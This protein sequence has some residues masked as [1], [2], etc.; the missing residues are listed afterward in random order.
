MTTKLE[1]TREDVAYL[2]ENFSD[3][4]NPAGDED[5][6]FTLA[7]INQQFA[8]EDIPNDVLIGWLD[9]LVIAR[10]VEGQGGL[11]RWAS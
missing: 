5:P 11:W 3:Y 9:E 10:K 7:Q 1:T 4:V 2:L 6:W 8:W